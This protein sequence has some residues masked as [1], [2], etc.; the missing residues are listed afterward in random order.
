M[1]AHF[2]GLIVAGV[3]PSPAPYLT[4]SP[5]PLTKHCAGPR[6]AMIMVTK[7]G[8]KKNPEFTKNY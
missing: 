4:S 2:A 3:Y 6:G 1:S 7:K 5:P 8:V